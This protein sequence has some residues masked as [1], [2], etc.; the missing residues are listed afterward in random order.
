MIISMSVETRLNKLG[1]TVV[2][3]ILYA[4]EAIAAVKEHRPDLVLMDIHLK[5][6]MLGT[7]AAELIHSKY[8]TPIIFLTAYSDDKTLTEAKAAEPYAFIKKPLEGEELKISIEM[9]LYKAE[10]DEKIREREQFL[11]D[12]FASIQDGICVLDQN[13]MVTMGNPHIKSIFPDELPLEGKHCCDFYYH[14]GREEKSCPSVKALSSGN[15]EHGEM[16]AIVD[17]K[18]RNLEIFSYPMR[19]DYNG[20][21]SGVIEFIR[22]ITERKQIELER[23]KNK[24]KFEA[25]FNQSLAICL[26]FNFRT[27]KLVE[28]NEAAARLAGMKREALFIKTIQQVI[29]PEDHTNLLSMI[30]KLRKNQKISRFLCRLKTDGHI[31]RYF[32]WALFP[33]DSNNLAYCIGFDVTER[34]EFNKRLEKFNTYLEERVNEE[35][36]KRMKIEKKNL[37]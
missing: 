34:E 32:E 26:I 13:L 9:A 19:Q 2:D 23:D 36:S 8:H 3:T 17:G 12:I 1:Y 33:D 10:I 27:M 18:E 20:K 35:I 24:K 14:G 29:H 28:V 22:D 30:K 25:F 37:D 7:E 21:P 15:T 6:E 16:L 4:E 5:G 31:Y 11:Q